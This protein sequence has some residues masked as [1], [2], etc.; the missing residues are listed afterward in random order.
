MKKYKCL[1][2]GHIQDNNEKCELCGVGPDKFVEVE[3][4]DDLVWAAEHELGVAKGVD[5][6]IYE[7]LLSCFNAE[8]TEV[9]M[10]LA[11][12][13][14]AYREGYPEVAE[15]LRQIA[16][17]EAEHAAKFEEL[18]Q[19][20]IFASTK[21]N[22]EKMVHGE[23]GACE[24]R[25]KIAAEAKKQNLDAIHDAVHEIS[26][27]EARHGKALQGMLNRYFK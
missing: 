7:G 19:D 5:P 26:K 18:A 27:D 10:Y 9:G 1:V 13:R 4:S 6:E 23:N 3:I 21:E 25:M 20:K 16:W 2:C 24:L 17:E 15:V 14:V 12:A 8:I 22:L 11:M